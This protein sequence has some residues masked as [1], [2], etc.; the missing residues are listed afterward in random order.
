MR[1]AFHNTDPGAVKRVDLF[2]QSYSDELKIKRTFRQMKS[3]A[4][5]KLEDQQI[6]A[7]EQLR[8]M[9]HGL[10]MLE[11]YP[12]CTKSHIVAKM[13]MWAV[14]NDMSVLLIAHSNAAVDHGLLQIIKAGECHPALEALLYARVYH[15]GKER[16]QVS[17]FF[18]KE[19]DDYEADTE[20]ETDAGLPFAGQPT[21]AGELSAEEVNLIDHILDNKLKHDKRYMNNPKVSLTNRT[22]EYARQQLAIKVPP[23]MKNVK[24]DIKWEQTETKRIDKKEKTVK[25]ATFNSEGKKEIT[26]E[27]STELPDEEHQPEESDVFHTVIDWV[28]SGKDKAFEDKS[29]KLVA[30]QKFSAAFRLAKVEFLRN[31]RV[32][33]CTFSMARSAEVR[34]HLGY[35]SNAILVVAD[36]MTLTTD[37]DFLMQF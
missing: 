13:I 28:D 9:P 27:P 15:K 36:E 30:R 31:A 26:E 35:K 37:P 6:H 1:K 16:K 2:A 22:I 7:I 3:C 32:L 29:Q 19:H 24:T 8:C 5:Y 21:N 33:A 25:V 14:L 10:L 34:Q 20:D 18:P 17:E 23:S 12:G 11:G 4:E